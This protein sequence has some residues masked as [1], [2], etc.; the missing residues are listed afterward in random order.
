MHI[1][2]KIADWN[3]EQG[4]D[5]TTP[6]SGGNQAFAHATSRQSAT[7]LSHGAQRPASGQEP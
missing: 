2:E 7:S 5:F 4:P 1:Q 3:D 6:G